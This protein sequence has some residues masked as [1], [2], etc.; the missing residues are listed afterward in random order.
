MEII[1]VEEAFITMKVHDTYAKN[2]LNMIV[3][4]NQVKFPY[5]LA[6]DL[7]MQIKRA[8]SIHIHK[9]VLIQIDK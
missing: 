9:Q 8:L 7:C 4:N 2:L 1:S 5:T 3:T 6:S